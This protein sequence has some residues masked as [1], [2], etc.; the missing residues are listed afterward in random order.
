MRHAIV[1]VNRTVAELEVPPA[2]ST[3]VRTFLTELDPALLA[4]R[5]S[6]KGTA[7][8]AEDEVVAKLEESVLASGVVAHDLLTRLRESLR[9]K[10]AQSTEVILI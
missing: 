9:D 4:A 5:T 1:K 6:G 10:R 3:R 2:T 7:S 8:A